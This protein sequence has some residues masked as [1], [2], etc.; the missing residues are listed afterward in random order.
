MIVAV[1]WAGQWAASFARDDKNA[2]RI[3]AGQELTH[4]KLRPGE[5]AR[6]P[7]IVMQFYQGPWLRAQNVW[8]RWMVAH[9][10]PRP[11]GKSVKP[12]TSICSGG[13][14]DDLRT[15]AKDEIEFFDKFRSEGVEADYWSTDAGWYPCDPAIGW[16]PVGTWE[17]GSREVSEGDS[18]ADRSS[19]QVWQEGDPLV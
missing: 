6:S 1:S 16:S 10:A 4:F 5:E 3:A 11:N 8:R 19:P 18:R 17:T 14:F 9:N 7:M 2:L 12:F 15:S 13:Y